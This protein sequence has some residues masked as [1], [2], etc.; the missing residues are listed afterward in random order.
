MFL[1]ALDTYSEIRKYIEKEV[2]TRQNIIAENNEWRKEANT[3][4]TKEWIK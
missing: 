3:K 4:E 1:H 2:I